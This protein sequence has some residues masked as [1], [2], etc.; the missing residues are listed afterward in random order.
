V[1]TSIEDPIIQ[2]HVSRVRTEAAAVV[3]QQEKKIQEIKEEIEYQ[4]HLKSIATN[5]AFLVAQEKP[6]AAVVDSVAKALADKPVT[7]DKAELEAWAKHVAE[8][9]WAANEKIRTSFS[10]KSNYINVRL[11]ELSG[12][13]RATA[14]VAK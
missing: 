3:A 2:K 5:R 6:P 1:T 4:K 10:S 9:E 7:N 11:S 8:T 12:R 13:F 14:Y